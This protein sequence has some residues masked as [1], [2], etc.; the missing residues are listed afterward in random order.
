M[1]PLHI[2]HLCNEL[3]QAETPTAFAQRDLCKEDRKRAGL[4]VQLPEKTGT[5]QGRTGLN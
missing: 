1:L 3:S 4:F 5:H 2:A